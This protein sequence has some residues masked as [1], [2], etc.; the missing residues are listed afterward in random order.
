[1]K[2]TTTTWATQT[3]RTTFKGVPGQLATMADIEA[4]LST[5][6]WAA[7]LSDLDKMPLGVAVQLRDRLNRLIGGSAAIS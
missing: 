2:Q 7:L 3:T 1:M 4:A 5:R 6:D